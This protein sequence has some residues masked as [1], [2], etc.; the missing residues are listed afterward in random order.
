MRRPSFRFRVAVNFAGFGA[1]VSLLL[2][3]GVY[4]FMHD[5]G[6]RLMDETLQA[7][8]QDYLSRL[9]RNPN[10]L[11]PSTLTLSAYLLDGSNNDSTVP[12]ALHTLTAGKHSVTLGGIPYRILAAGYPGKRYLFMFNA[13]LHHQREQKFLLFLGLGV[14][15]MTLLSSLGGFWLARRIVAPVTDLAA[16]VG[17][18][19][20]VGDALPDAINPDLDEVEELALIFDRYLARIQS[21]MQR[22][23]DFTANVSHE[24][25]T[26]LAI[27]RGA[28]EVLEEDAALN[29]EQRSRLA[30]IERAS[31]DMTDL[32]SALLHLAREEN[33]LPSDGDGCDM[34]QIVRESVEK[35]RTLYQDR[36]L[37]I[38]LD[39]AQETFLPVARIL[40]SVVVDNLV[41]NVFQHAATQRIE[42]QLDQSRLVIRDAGSGIAAEDL[43]QVFERHYRGAHSSGIGIGLSLVRR[44][45]TLNGW[46]P[47][48]ASTAG[49]GT[50]VSLSFS[51]AAAQP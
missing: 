15:V 18:A 13:S 28:V 11:L 35:Y 14:A 3:V 23:R 9:R 4:V 33:T 32:T 6:E 25:R 46:E 24:L 1:L 48:I 31:H 30:R 19:G 51:P 37:D 8:M 41:S 34:A 20:A 43:S 42:V 7:E 22:E 29:R 21:C 26:P 47:H 12:L 5:L 10:A 16:K 40:A 27:I 45:C 2:C 49:Q 38:H 39:I 50:T 44:I 36:S 17:A